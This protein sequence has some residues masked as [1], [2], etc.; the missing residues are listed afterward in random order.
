MTING[1]QYKQRNIVLIPF[2]FTDL[3][4]AK[5]RPALIIS[6][7]KINKTEDRICCLITSNPQSKGI[8]IKNIEKGILPFTSY[9]KPQRL[10]TIHKGLIKQNICTIS[11][12][13]Y[14][15]VL[16]SITNNIN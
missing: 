6:N 16:S 4:G 11:K 10:F 5:K 9:V 7:E 14:N 13:E 8:K 12:E 2:P 15:K 3:T 1:T